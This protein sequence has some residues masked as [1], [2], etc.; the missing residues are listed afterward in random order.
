MHPDRRDIATRKQTMRG[1]PPKQKPILIADER[2]LNAYEKAEKE[3]EPVEYKSVRDT[4]GAPVRVSVQG[5]FSPD[6]ITEENIKAIE[7]E[8]CTGR[9]HWGVIDPKRIVAACL[10]VC[11]KGVR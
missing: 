6:Q 5:G 10:N 3:L 9:A 1:R 7:A 8:L 4:E 2:P 11:G